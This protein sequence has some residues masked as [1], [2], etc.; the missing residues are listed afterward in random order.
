MCLRTVHSY[1]LAAVAIVAASTLGL[2]LLRLAWMKTYI[3]W[4]YTWPYL[5]HLTATFDWY[6]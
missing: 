1:E 5:C 4:Y 6:R 3:A 2:G